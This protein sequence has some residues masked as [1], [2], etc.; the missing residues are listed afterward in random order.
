MVPEFTTFDNVKHPGL[1][2][3]WCISRSLTAMHVCCVKL[4]S[5]LMAQACC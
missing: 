3:V 1:L 4:C 2:S 5:F